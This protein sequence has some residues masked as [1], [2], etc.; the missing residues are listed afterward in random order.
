MLGLELLGF[1]QGK[2]LLEEGTHFNDVVGSS[3]HIEVLD[4][5][6]QLLGSLAGKEVFADQ[7]LG[8][9]RPFKVLQS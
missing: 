7:W 1:G 6:C 2:H 9:L 3:A 5:H 4:S 8:Q